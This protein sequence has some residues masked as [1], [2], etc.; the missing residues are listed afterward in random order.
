[1]TLVS[2]DDR[3]AVLD[4]A[5]ALADLDL[6]EHQ[7]AQPLTLKGTEHYAFRVEIDQRTGVIVRAHTTYDDLDLLVQMA[8]L[9]ADKAPRV[10]ITRAVTIEPR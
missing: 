1:M 6:V 8:G 9:P 3:T 4:W 7:G 5:P 10:K 2:L